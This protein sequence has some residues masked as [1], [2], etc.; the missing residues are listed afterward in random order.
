MLKVW[1][2]THIPRS[3][4]CIFSHDDIFLILTFHSRY[5]LSHQHLLNLILTKNMTRQSPHKILGHLDDIFAS[6]KRYSFRKLQFSGVDNH[7]NRSGR[8]PT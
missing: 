7:M 5:I 1:D 2:E 6:A 3:E 8:G 4:L